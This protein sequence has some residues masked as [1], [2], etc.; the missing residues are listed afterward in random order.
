VFK[1]VVSTAKAPSSFLTLEKLSMKKT[2]IALAVLAASG[3]SFAQSSVTLYGI[4]D[5]G[6][7]EL[8][9]TT[10]AGAKSSVKGIS[11]QQSV[12]RIGFRG[13]EDLGGGLKANFTLEYYIEPDNGSGIGAGGVVSSARQAFAGISGAF[14]SVNAGNQTTLIAAVNGT[15]DFH[16]GVN[17][18]GYSIGNNQNSRRSNMIQ[19]TSP[20]FSGL[21]ATVQVGF[22]G[23]VNADTGDNQA[24]RLAYSN[25]PF[26]VAYATETTE[27]TK[28][29][30]G[31][32]GAAQ[33]ADFGTRNPTDL[34][35]ALADRKRNAFGATYDL[36]VAKV[37][38]T[39]SDAKAG[40]SADAGKFSVNSFG[41]SAP[42]GAL[43]L[44]ATFDN[45][46]FTDSGAASAKLGAYQLSA[47]YAL[48]KRTN[49][50]AI[51]GQV[52]N[53]TTEAKDAQYVVGLRHQ[54]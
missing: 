44:N 50:Y 29:S 6:Y 24:F 36:G 20:S 10:S 15:S 3:A 25:G 51:T 18:V 1:Q 43:T 4:V 46:K 40:S 30:V 28:L 31:N 27:L 35:D 5:A 7:G 38:F 49:V 19:Y 33:T 22:A 26:T 41:V 32:F 54:F 52:K 21:T 2:L 45:G 12:S 14:G 13:E 34:S 42:M 53:K 48:S 11:S 23:A 47:F 17:T 39:H 9:S 16:G 8:T 37:G